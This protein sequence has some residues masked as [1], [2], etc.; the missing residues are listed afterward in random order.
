MRYLKN[1]TTALQLLQSHSVM[2]GVEPMSQQGIR[3]SVPPPVE[4]RV[5]TLSLL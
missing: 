3:T 1:V 4:T 5:K 2:C